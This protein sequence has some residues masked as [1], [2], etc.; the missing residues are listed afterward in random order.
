FTDGA[1][2]WVAGPFGLQTRLN[3]QRFDW[4]AQETAF[5]AANAAIMVIPNDGRGTQP[6][7]AT[8]AD[9]VDGTSIFGQERRYLGRCVSVLAVIPPNPAQVEP[10][11]PQS[12]V[13]VW[14]YSGQQT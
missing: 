1:R 7:C 13:M 6:G 10:P 9:T 5:T 3:T 2:T 14:N 8:A 11:D 12:F 4:E